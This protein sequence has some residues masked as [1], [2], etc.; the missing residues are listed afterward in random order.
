MSSAEPASVSGLRPTLSGECARSCHPSFFLI[1]RC[2]RRGSRAAESSHGA[3]ED[4]GAR[5]G[6]RDDAQVRDGG[7][8]LGATPLARAEP[9]SGIARSRNSGQIGWE[10]IEE[11]RRRKQERDIVAQADKKRPLKSPA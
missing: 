11:R 6:L 10:A 9:I 1:C 8:G 3:G 7:L 5:L 4:A 2:G